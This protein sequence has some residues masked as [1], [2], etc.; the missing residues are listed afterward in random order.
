MIETDSASVA[1]YVLCRKPFSN[2]GAYFYLMRDKSDMVLYQ[3]LAWVRSR[4][5]R[6]RQVENPVT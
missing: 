1:V 5:T 2:P 3:F 6:M 4:L